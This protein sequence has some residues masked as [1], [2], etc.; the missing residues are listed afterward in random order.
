MLDGDII[1]EKDV[2]DDGQFLEQVKQK[3]GIIDNVIY[4]GPSLRIVVSQNVIYLTLNVY[5]RVDI[6]ETWMV[7]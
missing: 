1:L 3:L 7:F 6:I 5:H 2:K 4:I